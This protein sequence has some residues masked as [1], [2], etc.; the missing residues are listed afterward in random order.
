M[1]KRIS[2][3]LA[4]ILL[5]GLSSCAILTNKRFPQ[6]DT[7]QVE[8]IS[9]WSYA[10][11][12]QMNSE[13]IDKFIQLYH[14]SRYSGQGTG[15]GGTPE[16][17]VEVCFK[18][19]AILY[20]NDFQAL[21]RDF[22]VA[23]IDASGERTEW[24][25]INNQKLLEY[26]LSLIAA[27][28]GTTPT[29]AEKQPGP[30]VFADSSER[31]FTY[32]HR[33]EMINEKAEAKRELV[34]GGHRISVNYVRSFENALASGPQEELR[35]LGTFDE[36]D[37]EA[38]DGSVRVRFRQADQEPVFYASTAQCDVSGPLTEQE[39][40][41]L[42]DAFV[43]ERYGGKFV[44]EYPNYE[45]VKTDNSLEKSLTVCYTKYVSG[46][47]TTDRVLVTYN[48]NGELRGFN[49][50]TKGLFSAVE[51]GISAGDISNAEDTLS[52]SPY[53]SWNMVSKELALD[54]DGICYLHIMASKTNP[55]TIEGADLADFYIK[56]T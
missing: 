9:F 46:Y 43:A 12:K 40:K 2:L 50:M 26:L 21:D 45:I 6:I 19:G 37:A 31:D 17:G 56:I 1:K 47:P 25:Y 3:I 15:E 32:S 52:A 13:D 4:V 20:V 18:D 10:A 54:A 44:T 29:G 8:S 11:S 5:L 7:Q 27:K 42:A 53:A 23:L 24:C 39:A 41:N 48:M 16:F 55:E 14:G 51:S 33:T 49:A 28:P 36:Y 30:I 38:M 34:L 35:L 22:E